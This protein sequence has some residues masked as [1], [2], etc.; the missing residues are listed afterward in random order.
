MLECAAN[1]ASTRTPMP[2]SAKLVVNVQH[3]FWLVAS[4][5]PAS[6]YK[7]NISGHIVLPEKWLPSWNDNRAELN[8]PAPRCI[9][10]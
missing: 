10:P 9:T 7:R 5:M 3:L 6:K 8:L 4:A 2:F 1:S